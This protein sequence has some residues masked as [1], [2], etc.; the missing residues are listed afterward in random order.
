MNLKFWKRME[1][2]DIVQYD[3]GAGVYH[4]G[5]GA[6]SAPKL[7]SYIQ[8]FR[9][10]DT[11]YSC[12]GLIQ[13]AATLIPWGVYRETRDGKVE[14][15]DN[16]LADFIKRP[17]DKLSWSR[18]VETYLGHL[19]LSGNVFMRFIIGSFGKY[20]ETEFMR[21]N[22]VTPIEGPLGIMRYDYYK[23]GRIIPVPEEEVLH[24][25]TFN[26]EDD[27]MGLSP[28]STIAASVD[29]DSFA[30]A[31]MLALLEQGAMPP[32][33][34][35]AP[36]KLTPEQRD[37]LKEQVK[38][39]IL[40]Y[41][42]VMNPLIL[43]G[44]MK[45]EKVGFSPQEIDF[46][47]LSASVLRKICNVYKIASELL[48]DADNKTYSNVKEAEKALYKKATLPHLAMLR[49]ELNIGLVPRFDLP[50]GLFLDY[51]TSNLDALSEDLDLLWKR[52]GSAVDS[53]I[54][55]RNEARRVIKHEE[56]KEKGADVLTVSATIVPLEMV[57]GDGEEDIE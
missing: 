21:P 37:F 57:A 6:I 42:N 26:P 1:K 10:C 31:W 53:G 2:K 38:E 47:P 30:K 29:I 25:R 52:A 17:G 22:N 7:K 19:L 32:I 27:V 20:G 43:E 49:D 15:K 44:G 35:I 48:G 33:T 4:F 5:T 14:V 16:P 45:P 39:Q 56:S 8:A 41:Q 23:K 9:I 3:A 24:I 18:F 34:L 13:Q 51:D 54:I 55:T 36:G 11:V 12:I 50:E 46:Q 40:G 28:V